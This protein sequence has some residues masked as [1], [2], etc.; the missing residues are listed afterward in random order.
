MCMMFE[1]H[2]RLST[3]WVGCVR[4]TPVM[5]TQRNKENKVCRSRTPHSMLLLKKFSNVCEKKKKC[6][7]KGMPTEKTV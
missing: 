5:K 1:I 3:D 7:G 2:K 4:L 6:L